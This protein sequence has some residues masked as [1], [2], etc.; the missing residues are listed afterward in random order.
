M[1][2]E[3]I[4]TLKTPLIFHPLTFF[5][6]PNRAAAQP[7]LEKTAAYLFNLNIKP[8]SHAVLLTF[9]YLGSLDEKV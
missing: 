5:S 6:F 4:F 2:V 9:L 8:N 3:T 1:F 7:K